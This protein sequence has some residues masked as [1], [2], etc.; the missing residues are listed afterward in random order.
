MSSKRSSNKSKTEAPAGNP[1]K[2]ILILIDKM[3]RNAEEKILLE[4]SIKSIIK[5]ADNI[6]E[7][8]KLMDKEKTKEIIEMYNKILE[9]LKQKTIKL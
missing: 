7:H 5:G 3:T 2:E 8:I 6:A 1:Q 9:D 4:N